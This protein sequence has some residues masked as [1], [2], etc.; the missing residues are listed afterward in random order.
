MPEIATVESELKPVAIGPLLRLYAGLI[1]ADV[2]QF[3]DHNTSAFYDQ[4]C[5][6]VGLR[7]HKGWPDDIEVRLVYDYRILARKAGNPEQLQLLVD[8]DLHPAPIVLVPVDKVHFWNEVQKRRYVVWDMMVPAIL[9]VSKRAD[10]PSSPLFSYNI[11][12]TELERSVV[13]SYKTDEARLAGNIFDNT[14][15]K[16]WMGEHTPFFLRKE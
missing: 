6:G 10:G 4:G 11:A 1:G 5:I 3:G 9:G 16:V 8:H 15:F 12:M 2:K 13:P 14:I 7:H